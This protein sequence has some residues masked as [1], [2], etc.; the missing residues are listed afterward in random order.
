MKLK[1]GK[2]PAETQCCRMGT[3][4]PAWEKVTASWTALP[5]VHPRPP[6]MQQ[7]NCHARRLMDQPYTSL[8]SQPGRRS[9]KQ[10]V[11][12]REETWVSHLEWARAGDD[13]EFPSPHRVYEINNIDE[14]QASHVLG[15]IHDWRPDASPANCM[16]C[17]LSNVLLKSVSDVFKNLK[18][19]IL[20][21]LNTLFNLLQDMRYFSHFN[22][23]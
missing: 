22:I 12:F 4:S 20:Y 13:T 2:K 1:L 19:S 6:G 11:G 10:T 18:E 23:S 15:A 9:P 16:L 7:D 14:H 8:L 21:I 3:H 17:L 5:P